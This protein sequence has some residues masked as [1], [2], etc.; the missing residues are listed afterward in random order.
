MALLRGDVC[1]VDL[2]PTRGHEQ[3]KVRPCIVVSD[4]RFNR[5]G[6]GLVVVVPLTSVSRDVPWHVFVAPGD[7]G[8][9]QDSWAMVD[10]LRTVSR[11]RLLGDPWSRVSPAVLS[12]IHE[13]LRLLL[14]L[15]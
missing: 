2:D 3:A 11:E 13:R 8:V 5:S 6:S 7:G 12:Q 14:G 15:A 10:Q 1:V 4:D 9:R